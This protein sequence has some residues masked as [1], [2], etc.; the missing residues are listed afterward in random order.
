MASGDHALDMSSVADLMDGRLI[1]ALFF[2]VLEE[3]S[4]RLQGLLRSTLPWLDT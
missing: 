3:T 2:F 4:T 1:H